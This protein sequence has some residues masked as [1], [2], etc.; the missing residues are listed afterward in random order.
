M[1]KHSILKKTTQYDA[2]ASDAFMQTTLTTVLNS[3]PEGTQKLT[4]QD[5]LNTIKDKKML[6]EVQQEYLNKIHSW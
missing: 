2:E 6:N 5:I 3:V 4:T 1:I